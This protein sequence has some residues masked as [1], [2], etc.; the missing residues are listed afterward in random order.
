MV[1]DVLVMDSGAKAGCQITCLETCNDRD[2]GLVASDS[3]SILTCLQIAGFM[4]AW[5]LVFLFSL[6]CFPKDKETL[7]GAWSSFMV[8]WS[9]SS[10]SSSAAFRRP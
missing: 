7:W 9:A 6:V 8:A 1:L 5:L 2:S 3:V 10:G 4:V